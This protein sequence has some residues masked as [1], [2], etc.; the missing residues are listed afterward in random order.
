[1]CAVVGNVCVVLTRLEI[2]V[3]DPLAVESFIWLP[4]LAYGNSR[5]DVAIGLLEVS[6]FCF[7]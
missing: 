5:F 3:D 2:C 4:Q 1:M 6:S 7:S